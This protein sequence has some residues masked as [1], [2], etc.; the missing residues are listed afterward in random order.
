MNFLFSA[1][2]GTSKN[3]WKHTCQ[4]LEN[5]CRDIFNNPSQTFLNAK[6]LDGR[7]TYFNKK[8]NAFKNRNSHTDK[9][10][11]PKIYKPTNYH[12]V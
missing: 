8:K 12:I 5:K 1:C 3:T 6:A 4:H 2:F 10:S 11:S 9:S 7:K